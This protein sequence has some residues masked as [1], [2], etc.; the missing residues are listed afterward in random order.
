VTAAAVPDT[1]ST[2]ILLITSVLGLY[3]ARRLATA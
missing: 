2:M 1:S 3:C